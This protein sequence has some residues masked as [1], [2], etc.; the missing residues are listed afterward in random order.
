MRGLRD[1]TKFANDGTTAARAKRAPSLG[2]VGLFPVV[3]GGGMALFSVDV[4]KFGYGQ[5]WTN[6]YIIDVADLDAGI[7]VGEDIADLE[8]V[9]LL[10]SC[11]IEKYRVSSVTEGDDVYAIVPYEQAG[12]A[13]SDGNP[14][15]LFNVVRV[16]FAVGFGRPSRKYLRGCLN[17]GNVDG[18]NLATATRSNIQT[19]YATPLA[20][21]PAYVDVDGQPIVS[22]TV[23][24][25]IHMRQLRRG[26]RRQ[27][28]PVIP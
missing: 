16:D 17:E 4:Q 9:P 20:A 7:A 11:V 27:A 14:L 26:S 12:L 13:F 1:Y 21:L 22:A 25:A 18:M 5:Y 2:S 8:R 19:N 24:T 15:P 6:R 23:F 28:T 3:L 10:A